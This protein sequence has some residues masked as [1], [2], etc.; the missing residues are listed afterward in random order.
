MSLSICCACKKMQTLSWNEI[1]TRLG[2]V[3]SMS[4]AFG[5]SL[6]IILSLEYPYFFIGCFGVFITLYLV[7][8]MKHLGPSDSS[9]YV[10]YFMAYQVISI[11]AIYY[12]A[13]EDYQILR[14]L[15]HTLFL[16]TS[17]IGVICSYRLRLYLP[18]I[19]PPTLSV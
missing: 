3:L 16:C 8:S 7:F 15:T 11:C 2:M 17:T 6:L 10:T 4:A 19:S 14:I 1:K 18:M 13:A 5:Q 12:W 9:T